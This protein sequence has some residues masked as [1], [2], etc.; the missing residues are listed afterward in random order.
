[1][2]PVSSCV[3]SPDPPPPLES[4][5]VFCKTRLIRK[6]TN[7]NIPE[8]QLVRIAWLCCIIFPRSIL[9]H[10]VTCACVNVLRPPVVAC[11]DRGLYGPKCYYFTQHESE[12]Y[13]QKCYLCPVLEVE[14]K[15]SSGMV[16]ALKK[17]LI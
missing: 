3:C 12:V 2:S 11:C 8:A 6:F 14:K 10:E 16:L 7:P 5:H 9:H 17:Y 4:H 13:L 1:M 15:K